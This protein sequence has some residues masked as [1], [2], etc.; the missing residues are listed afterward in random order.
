MIRK[1]FTLVITL[2]AVS[3]FI[4]AKA[5][6]ISKLPVS[7]FP[8]NSEMNVGSYGFRAE[9]VFLQNDTTSGGSVSTVSYEGIGYYTADDFQLEQ[10]TQIKTIETTGYQMA[11]NLESIIT[12]MRVYIYSDD[13]GK[14][15]GVPTTSGT[16]LYEVEIDKD[17]A[18]SFSM[19]VNEGLY[20]FMLS[21]DFSAK[22]GERYWL[23]LA[24]I[25]NFTE[26]NGYNTN[27]TFNQFF[28]KDAHFGNAMSVDASDFFGIASI[29]WFDLYEAYGSVLG[30]E[31]KALAFALYEEN[32]V[33][34][35]EV[36]GSKTTVYPN[37]AYGKINIAGE[38]FDYC[39]IY[40]VLGKKIMTSRNPKVDVSTLSDGNYLVKVVLKSGKQATSKIIVRN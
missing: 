6:D 35:N 5:Q 37:P 31:I 9:A 1:I 39:E 7:V 29:G 33:N 10:D 16:P 26:G 20:H 30:E 11:N 3:L 36:I 13:N 4:T 2:C 27:E 14:P 24:P 34:V 28:S 40:D 17:D 15:S 38:E 21:V 12:G 8:T 18:S 32:C 23:V 22:A 25:V 19:T